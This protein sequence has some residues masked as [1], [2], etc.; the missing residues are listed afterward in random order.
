MAAA[1]ADVAAA[2]G[3]AAV[4]DAAVVVGAAKDV[5]VAVDVAMGVNVAVPVTLD[6]AGVVK[7]RGLFLLVD[8]A[9]CPAWMNFEF[10]RAFTFFTI[11]V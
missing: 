9:V 6:M 2:V 3:V 1:V 11:P 4:A 8:L 10:P 7:A 5:A